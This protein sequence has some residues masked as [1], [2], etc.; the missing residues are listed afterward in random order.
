MRG[1]LRSPRFDINQLRVQR[2]GEPRYN[3]VLH[4]EEVGNWFVEALG[5]QMISSLDVD[6]L[7]IYPKPVATALHGTFEDI[8]DVQFTSELLYVDGFTLER[9]RG[10]ARNHE[11]AIDARQV[12]G[13]ALGHP[14][15]EVL[16]LG[17]TAEVCEG[18]H[19]D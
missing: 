8:T 15:D 5:P 6:Q 9:E 2:I 18:Q 10:V 11:R 13:E 3:L 4:I 17:I 1:T 7:H 12:C 14:I 16:L 19:N